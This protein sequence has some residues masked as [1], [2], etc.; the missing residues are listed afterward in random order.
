VKTRS[1]INLRG[2]G[3]EELLLD[4]PQNGEVGGGGN[5]AQKELAAEGFEPTTK[6]L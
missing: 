3:H 6:G 5:Q 1:L 2:F 4:Y